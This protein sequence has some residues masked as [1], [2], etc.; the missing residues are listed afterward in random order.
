M[1]GA[2]QQQWQFVSA[3][4]E[5]FHLCVWTITLTE[6]WS[7]GELVGLRPSQLARRAAA[8]EPGGKRRDYPR[9]F[10]AEVI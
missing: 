2:G 1:V 5:S 9:D 7:E 10:L 8:A 4:I 3:R 6:A